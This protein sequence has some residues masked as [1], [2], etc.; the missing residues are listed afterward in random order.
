MAVGIDMSITIADVR[1]HAQELVAIIR[2]M[3]LDT[4]DTLPLVAEEEEVEVVVVVDQHHV[5]HVVLSQ[6]Q[7][8]VFRVTV[9]SAS[10]IKPARIIRS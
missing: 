2:S 10:R 9:H 5:P 8:R 1:R 4:V 7:G 6:S 3:T